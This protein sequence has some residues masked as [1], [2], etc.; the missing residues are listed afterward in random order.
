MPRCCA[1]NKCW[2]KCNKISKN[3]K[4]ILCPKDDGQNLMHGLCGHQVRSENNLLVRTCGNGNSGIPLTR[5]SDMGFCS[6]ISRCDDVCLKCWDEYADAPVA[7]TDVFSKP[8]SKAIDLTSSPP[9]KSAPNAKRRPTQGVKPVKTGKKRL[10]HR[11]APKTKASWKSDVRMPQYLD[12]QIFHEAAQRVAQRARQPILPR[13]KVERQALIS[14]RR[15]SHRP[16]S[17]KKEARRLR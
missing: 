12:T 7:G 3:H 4:C 16:E 10:C 11:S 2:N 8:T 15:G 9:V 1:G 6:D 5:L 14:H 13:P 17:K